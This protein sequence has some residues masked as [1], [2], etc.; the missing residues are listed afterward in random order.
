MKH[1]FHFSHLYNYIDD[2]IYTH[3]P[4]DIYDSYSTLIELLQDLGLDISQSKLVPPTT[5]AICLGIEIDTVNP[6]LKIPTEK[7]ARNSRYL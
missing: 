7:N 6:I 4:D 1:K 5:K 2:L 3:L